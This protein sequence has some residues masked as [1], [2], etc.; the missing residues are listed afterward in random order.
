MWQAQRMGYERGKRRKGELSVD[1]HLGHTVKNCMTV[2]E[3]MGRYQV[4]WS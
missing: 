2:I 1:S 4:T 3:S